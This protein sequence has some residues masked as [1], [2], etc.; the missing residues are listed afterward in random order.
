MKRMVCLILGFSLICLLV[1]S[2][3]GTIG[4]TCTVAEI[5]N[6]SEAQLDITL[7]DLETAGITPAAGMLVRGVL[8]GSAPGHEAHEIIHVRVHRKREKE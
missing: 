4:L 6:E 2:S 3:A 5:R 7:K 1:S 8:E